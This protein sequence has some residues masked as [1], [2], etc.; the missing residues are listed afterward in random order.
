[1]MENTH[2]LAR[3]AI[4][5]SERNERNAKAVESLLRAMSQAIMLIQSGCHQKARLTLEDAIRVNGQANH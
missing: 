1:M 2:S 5:E 4:R 3:Q